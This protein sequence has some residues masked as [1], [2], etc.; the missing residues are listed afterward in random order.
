MT[1]A[2]ANRT[3]SGD[4]PDKMQELSRKSHDSFTAARW[5]RDQA[6]HKSYDTLTS[7]NAA[8][9]KFETNSDD[10]STVM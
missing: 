2:G 7:K 3:W 4:S 6:P 5:A 10:D 1:I 9:W 8:G